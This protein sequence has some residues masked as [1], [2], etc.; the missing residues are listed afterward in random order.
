MDPD[1]RAVG[2]EALLRWE[3]PQRG[4]VQPAQFIPTAEETSLI[5]PIGH[6]VLEGA[7]RQLAAWARRPQRRHL[8]IAV[9]VSV[10]QFRHPDFVGD[11]MALVHGNG[12]APGRL[13]LELTESLLADNR[14]ATVAKMRSLRQMGVGISVDDFGVGYSSLAYL[15][16]LP[17]DE[18]KIDRAFVQDLLT[19]DNDAA[20]AATIIS[21][22][23]S[24]GLQ[25]VAE[26]VETRAQRDFLAR[27]GCDR[28]QG[29]LFGRPMPIEQLEA[30]LDAGDARRAGGSAESA[31]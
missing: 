28:Y 30:C 4:I 26:G 22:G 10:R 25:V 16:R 23:H 17:L 6:W 20:I 13:K 9:N 24:L 29:F 5:I 7:C 15:K 8:S 21:L 18:L 12:I 3:H 1:E 27:Q 31:L 14:D 2:V 11:V 19:D